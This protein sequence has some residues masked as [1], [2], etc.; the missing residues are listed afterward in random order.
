[1]G[2]A[3]DD[4]SGAAL[5]R[6]D[7]PVGAGLRACQDQAVGCG[8]PDSSYSSGPARGPGACRPRNRPDTRRLRGGDLVGPAQRNP[9]RHP[10]PSAHVPGD[11]YRNVG[12]PSRGGQRCDFDPPRGA[13]RRPGSR[14]ARRWGPRSR[15]NGRTGRDSPGGSAPPRS[16]VASQGTVASEGAVGGGDRRGYQGARHGIIARDD[17]GPPRCRHRRVWRRSRWKRR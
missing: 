3:G 2:D 9:A 1:V 13:L 10:G 6:G 17:T 8:R 7:H 5:R 4:R 12:E 16:V 11:A 15:S 14:T